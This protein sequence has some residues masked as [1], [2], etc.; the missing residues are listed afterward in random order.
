MSVEYYFYNKPLSIKELVDKTN[1]TIETHLD[2]HNNPNDW[3][4]DPDRNHIRIRSSDGDEIYELE[5]HGGQKVNYIMDTIVSQ[6]GITFYTCNERE[7]FS[8]LYH[9]FTPETYP[10]PQYLKENGEFDFHKAVKRDMK[11]FGN[12]EVIDVI[13]GIVNIPKRN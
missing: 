12:Y 3:I 11:H 10:Y 2:N 7:N 13:K 8:Q 1:L 4:I 5:N 6:F 9:N